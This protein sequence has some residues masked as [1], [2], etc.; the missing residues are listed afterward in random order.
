MG[1]AMPGTSRYFAGPCIYVDAQPFSWPWFAGI[2]L[3]GSIVAGTGR[4]RA[5]P[6]LL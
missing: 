3:H 5:G 4:S 6:V 1:L 2:P